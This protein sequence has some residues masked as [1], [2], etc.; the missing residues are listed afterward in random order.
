MYAI[1]EIL[2]EQVKV[3]PGVEVVVPFMGDKEEG[4][5]ITLDR[6]MLISDNGE[7]IIGQPAVEGATVEGKV[8]G[9]IKGDKVLVFKKK[10][11]TGYHKKQGHRQ[12]YT[13]VLV[14]KITSA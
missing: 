5:K 10:R 12:D 7:P 13:R 4:D 6:V 3:E 2:G 9:H 14:E 1:I 8:L 11:R